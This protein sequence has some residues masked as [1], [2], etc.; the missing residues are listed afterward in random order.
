MKL[1]F[2]TIAQ[3]INTLGSLLAAQQL[4][5]L[6]AERALVIAEFNALVD[7]DPATLGKND[8]ERELAKARL[9]RSDPDWCEADEQLFD[10]KRKLITLE[11][12][13]KAQVNLRRAMESY[14]QA[15]TVGIGDIEIDPPL[16]DSNGNDL[17]E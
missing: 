9:L 4:A 3:D 5:K 1:Q 16:T 8:K 14:L 15:A 2:L 12:E 13:L 17:D 6:H 11:M 7:V 10:A